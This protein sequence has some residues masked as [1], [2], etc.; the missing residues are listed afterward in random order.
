MNKIMITWIFL[1]VLATPAF[2]Q[3]AVEAT[4][5]EQQQAIEQQKIQYLIASVAAL[6]HAVFIRNGIGYSASKA[7][8]HMRLKLRFAG[9]SASTAEG[10]INCCATRSSM[11][12]IKYSIR[13]SDG[14]V[15]DAAVYLRGKLAEYPALSIKGTP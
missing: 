4:R 2:A 3:Q 5:P 9:A 10:F 6:H 7:A 11:S 14:H 1:A 8:A 15:V 13:F 12:G